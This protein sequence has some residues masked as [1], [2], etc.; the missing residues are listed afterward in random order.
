[1]Y[2]DKSNKGV[3]PPYTLTKKELVMETI[4][5]EETK[6]IRYL[7]V[8]CTSCNTSIDKRYLVIH[9]CK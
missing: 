2:I 5:V 6:T 4:V 1:M 8:T 7:F 3:Q 9:D